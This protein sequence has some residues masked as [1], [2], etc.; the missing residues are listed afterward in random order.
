MDDATPGLGEMS[1]ILARLERELS[2]VRSDIKSLPDRSMVDDL[3]AFTNTTV[4]ASEVKLVGRMDATK[5]EIHAEFSQLKA[6]ISSLRQTVNELDSWRTMIL[7]LIVGAVIAAL[8]GLVIVNG[9][10]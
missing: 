9:G 7:R 2:A 3:R 10:R 1:R 8:L 5:H 6:E 4:A